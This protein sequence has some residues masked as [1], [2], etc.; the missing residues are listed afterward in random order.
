MKRFRFP[1]RP[2]SVLR[3]HQE[4][5]AREV[6]AASVHTYVSA[7]EELAAMRRR[8][9][10]FETALFAGRHEAF[11]AAEEAHNLN[12][13]R[14]ECEATVRAERAMIEARE[15][16]ERRRAEYIEAHRKLEVI[17]RLEAKARTEHRVAANRAEQAEFDEFA[18]R[19]ARARTMSTL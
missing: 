18:G 16:M 6:F 4:L 9:A 7:E 13:Y 2:V 14:R 17:H 8:L 5:R 10:Q 15:M 3:A 1:L 12:G 19:L 11:S